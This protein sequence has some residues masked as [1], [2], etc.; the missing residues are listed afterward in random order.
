M[1]F[2]MFNVFRGDYCPDGT[3]DYGSLDIENG[4]TSRSLASSYLT[5]ILSA[6]MFRFALL[7]SRCS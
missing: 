7:P 6:G 2:G 3:S 5:R 1:M 4:T